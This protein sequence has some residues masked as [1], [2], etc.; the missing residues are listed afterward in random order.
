M[1]RCPAMI[2]A[3]CGGRPFRIASVMKI[4][5]KSC[6]VKCSGLAVGG[7]GQAGPGQ[8]GGEQDRGWCAAPMAR[9]SAPI[10]PLEQQRGGR[11]P[12][13]LVVVVG[14]GRAGIAPLAARSP[15]DDGAEH[16]GQLRRHDQQ[17]LVV[18]LGRGDLQ[19]R[20]EL[21][22][23]GQPVLDQA[24][25]DELGQLLD[26]DAGGAQDL[27][28]RPGPERVLFFAP[29][30]RRLPVARVFGPDLGGRRAPGD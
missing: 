5:R 3:M 24:V 10:V 1:S 22:G 26:P 7:V 18:G 16:V 20:H 6:G 29:R 25:V 27:D 2:W 11:Q 28:G 21:A 8:R 9:F 30:S 12:D 13:A 14:A 23:A 4:L 15:A 17:P 19:Q